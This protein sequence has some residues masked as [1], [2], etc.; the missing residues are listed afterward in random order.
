MGA[1]ALHFAG[2]M[3]HHVLLKDDTLKNILPG[4][5]Q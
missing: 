2:A 3:R 1:I 4:K 5:K